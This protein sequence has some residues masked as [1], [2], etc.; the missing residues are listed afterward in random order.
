MGGSLWLQ[1][2]VMIVLCGAVL[3]HSLPLAVGSFFLLGLQ[4]AIMG[5]ARWGMAKEL[6]GENVGEAAGW[7][8]MLGIVAILLGSL[9]GGFLIDTVPCRGPAGCLASV[10]SWFAG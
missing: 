4:S 10:L 5:P 8:E 9:A 7:M 1:L 6:A 2:A 3:F